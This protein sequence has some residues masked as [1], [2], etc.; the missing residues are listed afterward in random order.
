MEQEIIDIL[1]ELGYD[2]DKISNPNSLT[3]VYDL[4]MGYD[5][6][7]DKIDDPII[8]YYYGL[9]Y[10]MIRK[11]NKMIQ[12]YQKAIDQGVSLAMNRLGYYYYLQG[13]Y[14]LMKKN[15]LLAIKNNNSNAVINMGIYYDDIMKYDKMKK[16]YLMAFEMGNIRG[17]HNLGLYYERIKNYEQMEIYYLMAIK[18]GSV[19]SIH[20]L[21]KYYQ[22]QNRIEEMINYY[23]EAIEKHNDEF[24]ME[25]LTNH[26]GG[27]VSLVAK[28]ISNWAIVK[29]EQEKYKRLIVKKIPIYVNEFRFRDGSVTAKILKYHF[30]LNSGSPEEDIYR[31]LQTNNTIIINYLNI[32]DFSQVRE[33]ITQ[34]VNI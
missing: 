19:N 29:N 13:D 22:S 31:D 25:E 20:R 5:K 16:F 34:Y 24:S 17:V 9:H 30:Q 15:Y 27:K 12:Y 7:K 2:Y 26:F 10:E 21:A 33:K 3:V 18:R 23:M 4:L 14:K 28:A 32:N 11:S 6:K 8:Y 1:G